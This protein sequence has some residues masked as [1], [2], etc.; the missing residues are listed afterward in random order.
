VE[1]EW[2]G[3]KPVFL[4]IRE[5]ETVVFPDGIEQT[6]HKSHIVDLDE[7]GWTEKNA[8]LMRAPGAWML[9]DKAKSNATGVPS[10]VLIIQ[11]DEGEQPYFVTKHVVLGL[12]G[13]AGPEAMESVCYGIGKKRRDGFVDRLWLLPNGSVTVGEDV[14]WVADRMNKGKL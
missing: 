10:P 2:Q 14:Y 12:L 9:C 1:I 5:Y 8:V 4:L 13:H 11:V 6:V 7:P 3:D